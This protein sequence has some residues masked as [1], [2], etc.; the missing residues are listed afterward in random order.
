MVVIMKKYSTTFLLTTFITLL[1]FSYFTSADNNTPELGDPYSSTLPLKDEDIIGLAT[2]RRLQQYDY[3]NNDPLVI[4]YVN[5]LGNLL[6]RNV[7]DTKRKY[8]FFVVNS[9]DVNAFAVPGGYIGLNAGLIKLT[10]NEAQLAGVIAHEISHI[11]LRHS[12]EMIAS[13]NMNSISMWVGIIAGIFAGNTEASLAAFKL[14]LGQT[15]QANIDLIRANEVEADGYAVDIMYKSNYSIN[16]MANFFY[17]MQ[18]ATGEIQRSLAYLSTHPMYENRIA[19]IKNRSVKQNNALKNTTD[20]YIFIKNILSSETID[21]INYSIKRLDNKDKYTAHKLSLLY[22][23]KSDYKNAHKAIYQHYKKNQDNLYLSILFAKILANQNDVDGALTVLNHVK[24]IYPLNSVVSLSIAE[25]LIE[26]NKNL[27]YAEKLLEPL[28][29]HYSLN[30]NYLRL[31]SKLH[32]MRNNYYKSAI[33]L[34]DYYV[35]LGEVKVA[36]EVIDNSIKSDKISSLRKQILEKK[37]L[38]IICSGPRPLEPIFGEK[39]CN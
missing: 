11:K 8:N 27:N 19:N 4:S 22:F 39:T 30:P 29:S 5:Y 10:K 31:L 16:E 9:D 32:T 3:I 12:A 15:A 33:S 2:Y 18:N 21:D 17:D 34:S 20:D 13:S 23:K 1:L 35:L 37:K 7:L 28:E 38:S 24:N 14:G 25:I 26:N 36:L 6:S